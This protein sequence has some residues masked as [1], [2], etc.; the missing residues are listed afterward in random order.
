M[1]RMLLTLLTP[2]LIFASGAYAQTCA[3]AN[4]DG[5][6]DISDVVYMMAEHVGGQ[7]IPAGKGDIDYRQG[8]NAGD[9][10]FFIDYIF[11]GGP[12]PGCPPFSS[13]SLVNTDDSLILPSY[14]VPAGSGQFALPIYL[15]NHA[16]VSDMVL[17]MRVDGLGSTIFFD[18]LQI[19]SSLNSSAVR[20]ESVN[21]STGVIAFSIIGQTE[22]IVSGVNI[23][24][25]AFFHYTSS[26]GGTIS[27]D[28]ITI[29]SH[30][31]LNYV[32]GPSYAVGIPKVVVAAAA[33]IPNMTVQ[34]DTLAFE[35]P[36]S[37]ADPDPQQFS[38]QS[39]GEPFNW[40]LTA[41]SW[42]NVDATS[43]VS[44]QNIS[45]TPNTTGLFIGV[46]YGDIIVSSTGALG[47]PQRVVVKLTL[48]QQFLSLDA[49]CDGVFNIADIVA[50]IN[51]LFRGGSVCNPCT[52]E[53]P[54]GK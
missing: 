35:I 11:A 12:A 54:K 3:D 28:T 40:T 53:W 51:Y 14:V 29:R 24:A 22:Y 4:G 31:F 39:S 37:S 41:P 23:L 10:R 42:V 16:K 47:S 34:P 43:G 5:S 44:G 15:I 7:P 32:Y 9:M 13:Y 30:T 27:M 46:Y 17:P 45:V 26:L 25:L 33:T 50:Q 20:A 6:V 52:G 8:Y 36:V 2:M 38:I 21:G 18:S 1:L 49:N 48:K 19:E